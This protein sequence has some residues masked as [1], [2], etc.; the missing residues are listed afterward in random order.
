MSIRIG[1]IGFGWMAYYHYLHIVPKGE[2]VSIVAAFDIDPER[3]M[4]AGSLGLH[5][6]E[7]LDGFLGDGSF[8]T[9]LVATPNNLHKD[10]SIAALRAGKNVICEKPVALNAREAEQIIAVSEEQGRIFTVH[11]NRRRDADFLSVKETL[12]KGTIGAP[13]LVES[14]VNGSN[15]IPGDWRR[16]REAGGGMLL[17]WGPHL[18][19]QML[20]LVD[21][22]VVEIYAQLFYEK[23]DVDDNFKTLLKFKNGICAQIEVST[24]C[25]QPLPRWHVLGADGT[26]NIL[27]FKNEGSIVRG[28][29]KE[30]DWSIETVENYAGSTRTMRP[31]PSDTIETLENPKAATDWVEYYRNYKAANEGKAELL[32]KPAESLRVM[33][34]IDAIRESAERGE[35]VRCH[36]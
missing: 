21:G 32:V 28:A 2:G 10:M 17:D 31:R 15:G 6:H 19:D 30:V 16:S 35:S 13:F 20:M 7:G 23:Y 33:T 26:L 1:V 36:L 8:D 25:F 24:N 5:V 27:N 4:F 29:M 12:E 11:Q 18:V 3:R 14:R 34:I 22:P 9:V